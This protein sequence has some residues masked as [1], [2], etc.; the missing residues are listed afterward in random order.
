MRSTDMLKDVN[1]KEGANSIIMSWKLK[2]F[3][4]VHSGLER[5]DMKDI[6]ES[7]SV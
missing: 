4:H 5:T 6:V 3:G 1:I 2:Y 7:T